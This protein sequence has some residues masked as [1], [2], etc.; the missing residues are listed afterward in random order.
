M[1]SQNY[2]KLLWV[3]LLVLALVLAGCGAQTATA[4]EEA[5]PLAE[6]PAAVEEVAEAVEEMAEVVEEAAEVVEAV[7]FDLTTVV[8]GYMSGIPEGFLSVKLDAFKEILDT[9]EAVI[10]D[11]REVKEYEEGH[12]PGAINIPLRTLAQNLEMVPTDKPVVV[13]CKS[14]H[15]AAMATTSL[16]VLGYENVR[17]FA[18]SY[19]AWTAAEEPVEMEAMVGETYDVPEFEP[20]L[21]TAVDEFLSG[22]PEGWLA[23]GDIAKLNEA[24]DNGAFLVDVREVKEYEEGHI[25]GAINVPIRTLAQNLDQIPT[26]KPVFV[27]CKSG[28]RAALSIAALQTMGWSNVKSFPPGFTG[29]ADAGEPVAQ[30]Q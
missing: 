8:D 5:A 4:P 2:S 27:Y 29:W 12:V 28:Y 7:E 17:A 14:G 11:V 10:I 19:N 23:M 3:P 22:I 13:Y 16:Q 18:A 21:L 20:Q 15:R 24:I 30:V 1:F 25:P 9:G 26:D 6:G